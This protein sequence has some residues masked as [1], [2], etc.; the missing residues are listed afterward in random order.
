MSTPA[1]TTETSITLSVSEE[2]QQALKKA[3]AK[4]CLTVDEYLLEIAI[5]L[6]TQEIAAPE[7]IVL[8]DRDWD[9]FVL[10]LE[11]PPEPNEALKAAI[12]EHQ[13]KYGKR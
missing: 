10:G 12:K 11:N 4:R 8:S 6:A 3:A 13:E 5:N 2:Q 9:V 1:K 7:Q